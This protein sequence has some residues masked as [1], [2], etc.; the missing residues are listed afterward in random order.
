MAVKIGSACIDENGRISGG[1]SGD[2][3]GKEVTTQDWYLHK[4]GWDILR[5]NN[6]A[7]AEKIAKCMENA[8][9]NNNIGYDQNQRNTLYNEASKYGFDCAKVSQKVETDCSALVR[10]CCKYAGINVGD[11]N[12]AN[13]KSVLMATKAFTDE[14]ASCGASSANLK[15]GDILVTKTKGHTVVVLTNGAV[16]AGAPASKKSIDEIVSEVIAGKWGIGEDRKARL[17]AAGYNYSE[18]Q[19]AV[20][21]RHGNSDAVACEYRI[22]T[23]NG[24]WIPAISG[25]K[26]A[27]NANDAITDIAIA[28]S[29]SGLKYQVHV[30]GGKWLP[31]V[32]GYNINDGYNGYAGDHHVIDAVRVEYKNGSHRAKYRVATV[33]KDFWPYQ[34]NAETGNGQDGY[35]GVFGQPIVK[36]EMEIV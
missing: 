6:A 26:T 9:A 20:N 29:Q 30:L 2:Q 28:A 14:T 36:F 11:F 1:A 35:A 32:T 19:A 22:K 34:Y 25:S 13:E 5:P 33:G 15:R 10:V 16:S 17:E 7:Q 31:W 12:T 3:T 4:Q 23:L 24:G 27:W 21:A 8:C 18:V